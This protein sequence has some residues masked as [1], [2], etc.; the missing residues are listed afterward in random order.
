[1]YIVC[2]IKKKVKLIYYNVKLLKRH[3]NKPKFG[4]IWYWVIRSRLNFITKIYIYLFV[5]LLILLLFVIGRTL[6]KYQSLILF[7]YICWF[8]FSLFYI[9]F[10]RV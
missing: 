3:I 2:K 9:E 1:M 5:V 6:R 8:C 4:T 7:I 10:I